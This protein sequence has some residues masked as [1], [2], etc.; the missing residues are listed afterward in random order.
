[1][2]ILSI[3]TFDTKGG[4]A[5]V[6]WTLKQW[7]E[8]TGHSVDMFVHRKHSSDAHVHEIPQTRF[9]RILSGVWATDLH[10]WKTDYILETP[11]FK[12]ADI[13]HLHNIH[14][15]FFNHSTFKKMCLVKPV[16]WTL[17]DMWALTGHNA[18]G[19][20]PFIGKSS[21]IPQIEVTPKLRWDNSRSL[22]KVKQNMYRYPFTIVTPSRWLENEARDSIL[23]DHRIE[24][25]H[26]G[27]DTDIFEPTDQDEARKRLSL[28][29]GKKIVLTVAQ[30]GLGNPQKGGIYV[31]EIR[32]RFE[33]HEDTLFIALG[34]KDRFV[35]DPVELALY[36]SAADALLFTSLAE[37][38]PLVVLEALS[39]GLPVVSFDVGGVGEAIEHGEH[40]YIARYKDAEDIATGLHKILGS[41]QDEQTT[42]RRACRARAIEE[43]GAGHMAQKYLDLYTSLIHA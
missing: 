4:A 38:L 32:K 22:F 35:R 40:G 39:C 20:E 16:V 10:F 5:K 3:G 8:Q 42:M 24:M 25:I 28:P 15:S 13:V 34:G 41:S 27:I 12:K 33:G 18:W 30:G 43:F 11:Q 37:N 1:M 36:Y 29:I 6:S 19:Y 7:L 31:E 26:N 21:D 9:Q 23:R 14:G 2:N 17:H